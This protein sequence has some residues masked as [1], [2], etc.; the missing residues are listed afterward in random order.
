MTKNKNVNSL[1]EKK[2]STRKLLNKE[3]GNKDAVNKEHVKI[4]LTKVSKSFA[5]KQVLRGINLDI[6]A[7]KSLVIIGGS[8]SG[9]SVLL[10][11]IV[12]LIQPSDGVIKLDGKDVSE[13]S[14]QQRSQMMNKF[15][16]LFQGGAL[17][18]SLPVWRNISFSLMQ[19]K[20]ISKAEAYDLAI[21]K[22][23]SVGLSGEVAN[24]FPSELSGGM[25]KRVALARAIAHDPE[26]I[27]FD[28]PT[29][30]LDPIMADI[31]ND[32]I[33]ECS[34]KL[35]A[36]TFTITHD[37][38]SAKKIADKVAMIYEGKIIWH[39]N[40]DNMEKTDN[41]YVRQFIKGSAKGPIK[42]KIQDH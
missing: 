7:G 28:E 31:I 23:A 22:L 12:G 14:A 30:G 26:V 8:G 1:S 32:L 17:F 21:S 41:E 24:L 5:S 33:V 25:Q 37:M 40:V 38:R 6:F 19:T 42:M 11:S 16:V 20:N 9:K 2:T 27:F 36:T 34:K 35:G 29:T 3:T 15:G 4:S 10:K 18:D 13:F 39:D